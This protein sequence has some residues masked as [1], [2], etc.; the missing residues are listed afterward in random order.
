MD[1]EEDQRRSKDF[2]AYLSKQLR[3]ASLQVSSPATT[4]SPLLKPISKPSPMGFK[5]ILLTDRSCPRKLCKHT[6]RKA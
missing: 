4:T 6:D 5:Q 1:A 3:T 2:D